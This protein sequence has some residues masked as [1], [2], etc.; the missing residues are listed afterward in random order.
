MQ[1]L[2]YHSK[3]SGNNQEYPVLNT[4]QASD[5]FLFNVSCNPAE[6]LIYM[7]VCMASHKEVNLNLLKK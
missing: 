1:A 2:H 5:I 7:L 6:E 3:R 4:Y